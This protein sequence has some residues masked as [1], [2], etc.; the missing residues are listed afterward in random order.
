[1]KQEIRVIV[2]MAA[3]SITFMA[4][5][6]KVFTENNVS[7]GS[8][9][10]TVKEGRTHDGALPI[11][12]QKSVRVLDLDAGHA[13]SGTVSGSE[14]FGDRGKSGWIAGGGKGGERKDAKEKH[15]GEVFVSAS[16]PLP[17]MKADSNLSVDGNQTAVREQ[18][19]MMARSD[20]YIAGYLNAHKVED[21]K[22]IY[23]RDIIE[24]VM[25]RSIGMGRVV[26]NRVRFIESV[27]VMFGS[28]DVN[29]GINSSTGGGY[30]LAVSDK[31]KHDGSDDA[32]WTANFLRIK[33][34]VKLPADASS[35]VEGKEN[36][37]IKEAVTWMDEVLFMNRQ[38]VVTEN[39]FK[40]GVD[41][42]I[43]TLPR[44]LDDWY[45]GLV[46]VAGNENARHRVVVF[47][48][49]LCEECQNEM[50]SIVDVALRN[51]SDVAL[52][53][54]PRPMMVVHPTSGFLVG[55][56]EKAVRN[57]MLFS[58]VVKRVYSGFGFEPRRDDP[59]RMLRM[60]KTELGYD[61][62]IS[63]LR[64][65]RLLERLRFYAEVS[66]M[67]RVKSVPTCYVDGGV[68]SSFFEW[69]SSKR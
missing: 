49:P 64:D 32:E 33:V 59:E 4:D 69:W 65:E 54:I 9:A 31:R 52:Y 58:D 60:L 16:T 14:G 19:I 11:G 55:A 66:D 27:P 7:I 2:L 38:G 13:V 18:D 67:M 51:P 29:N 10:Y 12:A 36:K 68:V 24:K 44:F 43:S 5:V 63:D 30:S 35:D 41:Y 26:I 62:D 15:G 45:R 42:R 21:A 40:D 34:T 28:G 6:G 46:L 23:W 17:D 39:L 57:G 3:I 25:K 53:Y 8:G 1:M 56:M 22:D 47:G 20:V 61:V 37:K 50:P 48:D